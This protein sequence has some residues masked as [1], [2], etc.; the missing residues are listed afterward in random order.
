MMDDLGSYVEH[1]GRPAV[2]FER[3]YAHPVER[4]WAAVTEPDEL[5]HWFPST[6]H[7]EQRAGGRVRFSGDPY[8]EDSTGTVLAFEPLRHLAFTWG[9]DEVHLYVE[10]APE[11]CRLT[12]IDVLGARDEAARNG[13][14]WHV[15]LEELAK[16]LAGVTSDGPHGDT[17]TPWTPTYDAYVAAGVPSGAWVPDGVR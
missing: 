12:F 17:T 8:T 1:D 11:G 13:A 7:L 4:V 14:G 15:C 3:V 10:P 5:R 2:R 6:I 16:W 9:G